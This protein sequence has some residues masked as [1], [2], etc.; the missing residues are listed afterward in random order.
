MRHLIRAV[1]FV[2]AL[3]AV[4]G[5]TMTTVLA[6]GWAEVTIV[7][8]AEE[9]PV[10]GEERE[11]RLLML[12]H[13]VR[14][15]NHGTVELQASLPGSGERVTVTATSAGGGEWVATIAFPVEGDWQLRATHNDL[16][17]SPATAI[18][19][20]PGG[21]AAWFPPVASVAGVALLAVALLAAARLLGGRRPAERAP[22]GGTVR[23]G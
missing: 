20:A 21:T 23:V 1:T 14:P 7:G 6:G 11:I 22:A 16:A 12:Q 18:A 9:P 10:A 5:L 19:V 13:G 3:V 4:A 17:T 8:G 15:V 2:A